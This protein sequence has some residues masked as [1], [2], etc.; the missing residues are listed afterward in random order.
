MLLLSLAYLALAAIL[1][2]LAGILLN[3]F[4][5]G[6]VIFV[7]S[8]LL[9]AAMWGF[10]LAMVAFF[11]RE[12]LQTVEVD[13]NGIREI[14]DGRETAFI[15]WTGTR[16]IE[17]NSTLIAGGSLRIKGNF[18]EIAISNIDVMITEPATIREMH[19]AFNQTARL[20]KLFEQAV[21]EAPE[22]TI[23]MNR[24]ARRKAGAS[25]KALGIRR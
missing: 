2:V 20:R 6:V 9:N 4:L 19:R 1:A 24:L 14:R 17:F 15:P 5:Y 7:W 11:R 16:E 22:A 25:A 18:S 3:S 13:Q 23:K 21:Q 8:S 10:Y 12:S